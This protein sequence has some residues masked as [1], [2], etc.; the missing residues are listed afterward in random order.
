MNTITQ[1]ITRRIRAK[2][3][4]W[5]F[6]PK[7]FLDVGSRAA[8]DQTL[9]RLVKQGTIRRLDRGVYD[10]PKLHPTLGTLSPSAN[11]LAQAIATQTGDIAFPSGA[12][13]ANLLG[14][15]TQVPAKPVFMTN[16]ASRTKRIAG[17]SIKLQHARVPIST[18]ISDKANFV[19]QALYYL[20]KN[21]I[22][23][24]VLLKCAAQMNKNDFR[25]LLPVLPRIPGWMAD[26]V[27]RM[28]NL[29]H[30]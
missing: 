2:K 23:N 1:T 27:L 4:G 20:G 30:G 9:S 19:L 5:V 11:D 28:Q 17:R 18:Q 29:Q 24:A 26:A 14:L 16:G 10:F 22:D 6:T 12:T 3:R 8:I 13:A 15:S 25:N 7:D 21:N